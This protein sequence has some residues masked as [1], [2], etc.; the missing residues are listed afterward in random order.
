MPELEQSKSQVQIEYDA[1]ED[2]KNQKRSQV[3]ALRIDIIELEGQQIMLQADWAA[4][5]RKEIE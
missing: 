3:R 1:I 5:Q 4:E 2:V